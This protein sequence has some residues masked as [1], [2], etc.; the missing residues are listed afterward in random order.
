M[1]CERTTIINQ[2]FTKSSSL[3]IKQYFHCKLKIPNSVLHFTAFVSLTHS[4]ETDF[5]I[6]LSILISLFELNLSDIP[7][8]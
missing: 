7:E 5:N 6:H 8:S 4:Q 2:N 1:A 3:S